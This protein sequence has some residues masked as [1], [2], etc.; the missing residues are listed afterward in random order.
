M[1]VGRL[2][3]AP[4]RRHPGVKTQPQRLDLRGLTREPVHAL[5]APDVGCQPLL[6]D[7]C[8]PTAESG[9]CQIIVDSD[10]FNH[11]CFITK[12]L[13]HTFSKKY[14]LPIK[15]HRLLLNGFTFDQFTPEHRAE[16]LEVVVCS[17]VST[18]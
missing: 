1:N 9:D 14:P 4:V 8:T 12:A 15:F 17:K 16:L 2:D 5:Q 11:L 6:Y 13:A 18:Q 3:P 7:V 10:A